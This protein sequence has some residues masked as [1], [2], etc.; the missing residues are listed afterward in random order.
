MC[1][2]TQKKVRVCLK[3]G[4]CF[5]YLE[6]VQKGKFE[7]EGALSAGWTN[8]KVPP[9]TRWCSLEVGVR[10]FGSKHYKKQVQS[11]E[12]PC[13]LASLVCLQVRFGAGWSLCRLSIHLCPVFM[14]H[15]ILSATPVH[16]LYT[17]LECTR[18]VEYDKHNTHT[19]IHINCVGSCCYILFS[20]SR[21]LARMRPPTSTN[22]ILY[23]MCVYYTE[24]AHLHNNVCILYRICT[25]AC[26]EDA[27]SFVRHLFREFSLVVVH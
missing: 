20:V 8:G 2:F 19:F 10:M 22:E 7:R 13:L 16:T 9:L 15:Y 11:C 6:S 18:F 14:L 12:W 23:Y 17:H 25:P 1:L 24:F 26:C 21:K 3:N 4:A 27:V 5:V